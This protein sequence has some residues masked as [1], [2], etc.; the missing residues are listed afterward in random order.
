MACNIRVL[1]VRTPAEAGRELAAIGLDPFSIRNMGP[2]M[3]QRLLLLGKVGARESDIL[4]TA[5]L[6]IGG[7]AAVGVKGP[8]SGHGDYP[9]ILMGTEKQLRKLCATLMQ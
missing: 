7:D 8:V 4:K 9:V 1:S 3:I 6:A 2:K 5:I